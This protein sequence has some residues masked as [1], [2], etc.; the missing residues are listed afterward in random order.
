M[1]A[2][3]GNME[4]PRENPGSYAIHTVACAH[5]HTQGGTQVILWLAPTFDSTTALGVDVKSRPIL[6]TP[7]GSP[8]SSDSSFQPLVAHTGPVDV[9]G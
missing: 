6:G 3:N 9:A 4:F 7:R 8:R 5:S 2:Y 1:R